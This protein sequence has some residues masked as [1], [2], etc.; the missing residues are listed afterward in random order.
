MCDVTGDGGRGEH[1]AVAS[2]SLRDRDVAGG[3][4]DQAALEVCRMLRDVTFVGDHI[5]ADISVCQG[6]YDGERV[7]VEAVV[8]TRGVGQK[9]SFVR[10]KFGRFWVMALSAVFVLKHHEGQLIRLHVDDVTFIASRDSTD[11]II[12]HTEV[13]IQVCT[14]RQLLCIFHRFRG[15]VNKTVVEYVFRKLPRSISIFWESICSYIRSPGNSPRTG[16]VAVKDVFV[17]EGEACRLVCVR[18]VVQ[19]H[20]QAFCRRYIVQHIVQISILRCWKQASIAACDDIV[21]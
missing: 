9:F 20:A 5:D 6:Q 17:Q 2:L 14:F 13:N 10:E 3:L 8:H 11:V 19:K 16:A 1:Q 15:E 4:P 12:D 18:H 7:V 21:A